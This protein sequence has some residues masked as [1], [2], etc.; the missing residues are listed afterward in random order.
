[1]I[2][3]KVGSLAIYREAAKV[4]LRSR[5]FWHLFI[6]SVLLIYCTLFYYFGTLVDLLKWEALRID[7]FYGAHVVQRAFF[8]APII[9]TGY[10]FGTRAVI[11]VTLISALAILPYILVASDSP[12]PIWRIVTF[13]FIAGA[14]GYITARLRRSYFPDQNKEAGTP[15][16]Y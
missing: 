3:K 4:G 6:L 10:V 8:L 2:E 15:H 1:M 16:H 14:A 9:Y 7:F 13:I 5:H 11:I 12:D